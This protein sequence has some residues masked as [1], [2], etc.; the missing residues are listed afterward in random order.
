MMHLHLSIAISDE[1]YEDYYF[2]DLI[3]SSSGNN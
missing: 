3:F 2:R 1:F